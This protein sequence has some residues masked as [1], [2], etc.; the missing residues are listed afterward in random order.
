MFE[1]ECDLLHIPIDMKEGHD[2]A[3]RLIKD[4]LH[5]E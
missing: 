1:D 3:I 2:G 5:S 4:K